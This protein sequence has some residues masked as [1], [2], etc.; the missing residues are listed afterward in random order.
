M[1]NEYPNFILIKWSFHACIRLARPIEIIVLDIYY[2]Y[3]QTFHFAYW[4]IAYQIFD[5][6]CN[7]VHIK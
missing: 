2:F 7:L 1:A 5:S 4:Q 6:T 3:A